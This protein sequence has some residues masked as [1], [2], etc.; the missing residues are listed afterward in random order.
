MRWATLISVNDTIRTGLLVASVAAR[1]MR[2]R[3]KLS[4][5]IVDWSY[6]FDSAGCLITRLN[7]TI[8]NRSQSD[9]MVSQILLAAREDKTLTFTPAKL[10][11]SWRGRAQVRLD[12]RRVY[13]VC[14]KHEV[15]TLPSPIK[16]GTIVSGW[17]SF[18]VDSSQVEL[19][20]QHKWYVAVV[21]QDGRRYKSKTEQ[22]RSI[23]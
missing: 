3:R 20:S 14:G 18:V 5:Y 21:D 9:E 12:D 15:L 13:D 11:T 6:L 23:G 1:I 22:D 8:L 7:I 2:S 16:S 17:L 19:V 4:S 10:R